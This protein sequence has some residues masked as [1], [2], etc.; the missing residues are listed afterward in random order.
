MEFEN[1]LKFRERHGPLV[2]PLKPNIKFRTLIKAMISLQQAIENAPDGELKSEL[3]LEYANLLTK[4]NRHLEAFEC[5]NKIELGAE[6]VIRSTNKILQLSR[7][8][9]VAQR[10]KSAPNFIEDRLAKSKEEVQW[11]LDSRQVPVE[12]PSPAGKPP[13]GKGKKETSQPVLSQSIAQI[14]EISVSN[15]RDFCSA[16]YHI[17]TRFKDSGH[18]NR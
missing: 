1:R 5:L 12:K 15:A 9:V 6:A 18:L 10:L 11:L 13:S 7:F 8:K 3:L 14:D 4:N 16:L 2:A 17:A